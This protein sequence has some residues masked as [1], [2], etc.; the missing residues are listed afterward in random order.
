MSLINCPNCQK[1]IS[2]LAKSC[3]HCGHPIKKSNTVVKKIIIPLILFIVGVLCVAFAVW[4]F[5]FKQDEQPIIE[6]PI[7]EQPRKFELSSDM[8]FSDPYGLSCNNNILG[9]DIHEVLATYS[10]YT[11]DDY[12]IDS[13]ENAALYEFYDTISTFST[14]SED[15][16]LSLLTEND[17]VT[18]IIYKG[19]YDDYFVKLSDRALYKGKINDYI[20]NFKNE[21]INKLDVDPVYLFKDENG[22]EYKITY[23]EWK[24][25]SSKGVKSI[26]FFADDIGAFIDFNNFYDEKKETFTIMHLLD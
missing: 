18:A 5:V 20:N 12:S 23:D 14:F 22:T 19:R 13:N 25:L 24:N 7:I 26:C 4:F 8:P 3:P 6:Q 17:I 10:G 9:K 21:V 11:T 16:R 1:E 15:T 2:N